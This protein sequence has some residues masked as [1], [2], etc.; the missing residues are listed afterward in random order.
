MTAFSQAG[1]KPEGRLRRIIG[2]TL[3]MALTLTTAARAAGEDGLAAATLRIGFSRAA[4]T[5]LN[6]SDTTAA[7]RA[8]ATAL[9]RKRGYA[10]SCEF[11]IFDTVPEAAAAVRARRVQLI[12][13]SAWQLLSTDL[14]DQTE[15]AFVPFTGEG[16]GRRLLLLARNDRLVRGP[17]DLRGGK[18]LLL[19]N[20]AVTLSALWFETLT[21]QAG[22]GSPGQLLRKAEFGTKP[23]ALVLSVFFGRADACVVDE[24][25]FA[26]AC[27]LNPQLSRELIAVDRSEP[28]LDFVICLNRDGWEP[29]ELLDDVRLSMAELHHEPMG[30]QILTL[31]RCDRLEPFRSEQLEDLAALHARHA[32]LLA[33]SPNAAA[34][35]APVP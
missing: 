29:P 31:F 35:A 8:F 10:L 1:P 15:I 22:L 20:N 14:L 3:L 13:L 30:R 2:C 4:F 34:P 11:S 32:Q 12:V 25:S 27:E 9:G 19:R 21:L 26:V 7:Y 5:G 28:L 24:Q 18:L 17:A 23:S 16:V 33:A 6:E